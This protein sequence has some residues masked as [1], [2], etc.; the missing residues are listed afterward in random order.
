VISLP[1]QARLY[2]IVV[3]KRSVCLITLVCFLLNGCTPMLWKKD[4]K[5]KVEGRIKEPAGVFIP[6]DSAEAAYCIKG[7]G[8]DEDECLSLDSGG[9]KDFE[10]LDAMLR[11]GTDLDIDELEVYMG[12]GDDERPVAFYVYINGVAGEGEIVRPVKVTYRH[13]GAD[14]SREFSA[15]VTA[16]S[17]TYIKLDIFTSRLA[18]F[19]ESGFREIPA[20]GFPVTIET[21]RGSE[22]LVIFGKVL[23]TPFTLAADLVFALLYAPVMFFSTPNPIENADD[24]LQMLHLF[25]L[26]GGG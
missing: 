26:L 13:E 10:V 23:L 24:E 1:R 2:I 9:N 6:V 3:M 20:P 14:E 7:P 4:E 11:G 8:L 25:W 19:S 18:A 22:Y 5:E 16:D 15:L 12:S 21:P 17:G